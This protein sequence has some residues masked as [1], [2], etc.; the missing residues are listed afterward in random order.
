MSEDAM[1][2]ET[3]ELAERIVKSPVA[4]GS[5]GGHSMV[6]QGPH[7]VRR[8]FV[9]H[10]EVRNPHEA[11]APEPAHRGHSGFVGIIYASRSFTEHRRGDG[12]VWVEHHPARSQRRRHGESRQAWRVRTQFPWWDK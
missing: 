6:A 4:G 1:S 11:K 9:N 10:R 8:F 12:T 2:A 3:V 5:W 7:K